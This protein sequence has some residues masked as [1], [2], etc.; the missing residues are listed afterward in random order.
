MITIVPRH[1]IAAASWNEFPLSSKGLYHLTLYRESHSRL[2]ER[3]TCQLGFALLSLASLVEVVAFACL[4]R[5]EP[6]IHAA[7]TFALS[8]SASLFSL[9]VQKV[10]PTL[11]ELDFSLSFWMKDSYLYYAAQYGRKDL[12]QKLLTRGANPHAHLWEVT[13]A[14]SRKLHHQK[15]LKKLLPLNS[16]EKRYLQIQ[17]LASW[18]NVK[19]TAKIGEKEVTLEGSVS[20]WIFSSVAKLLTQYP[21]PIPE[22]LSA[23]F[24]WAAKKRTYREIAQRVQENKLTFVDSGWKGH[25]VCVCFSSSYLAICNLGDTDGLST[26]EVYSIDPKKVTPDV[27]ESILM[28]RWSPK[29]QSLSFLYE[30]LPTL[31]SATGKKRKDRVCRNFTRIAPKKAKSGNCTLTS[32][33]GALRFGWALSTDPQPSLEKMEETRLQTKHFTD[34]AA[35]EVSRRYSPFQKPELK[36]QLVKSVKRKGERLEKSPYFKA[37]FYSCPHMTLQ[38]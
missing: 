35:L 12:V 28:H 10:I 20:P 30:T 5:R 27:I 17:K 37:Y 18:H 31:L 9:F 26:L 32:K 19:G 4:F 11:L 33:K 3:V 2:L 14:F 1:Q 6:L 29:E 15:H 16:Y 22:A 23:A 13:P 25:S 24:S 36:A 7:R 34:W 38:K 8:F 21:F